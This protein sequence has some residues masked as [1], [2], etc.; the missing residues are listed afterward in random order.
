[1]A[2]SSFGVRKISSP[3]KV[4]ILS[5]PKH[6]LVCGLGPFLLFP[7]RSSCIAYALLTSNVTLLFIVP[8]SIKGVLLPLAAI[9]L[10]ASGA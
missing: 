5:L 7:N 6:E 8:V 2:A 3:R 4:T 10:G 1:M 9:V